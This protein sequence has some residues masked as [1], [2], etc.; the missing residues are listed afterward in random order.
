MSERSFGANAVLTAVGWVIPAIAALVAVPI[1]VRG[2]GAD[3]FGLLAL[4][5]ALS[6]YLS[7]LDLGLGTAIVRYLAY[8]CARNEGRTMLQILRVA[9]LWFSVIG[10]LGG[11]IM[12]TQAPALAGI[13][14]VSGDLEPVAVTVVRLAG[15][16]FFL[17]MLMSAGTAI[18]QAFLR[19][20]LAAAVSGIIGTASAVGPAVLVATGHGIVAVVVFSIITNLVALILYA[21]IAVVLFRGVSLRSGPTWKEIRRV[22]L[23]FT[24]MTAL[25]RV[26]S[27]IA[28]QTNRLLVGVAGGA[29]AMAYYQVPNLL[30]SKVNELLSRV[31]QVI[32]PTGT[33]RI[34][35]QNDEG[36]R[37]LYLRTSRLFFVLNA[38][39]SVAV[40]A[41]AKPLLSTWVSP[42]F[43][44]KGALA[45]VI[46]TL[47]QG[48]NA[49]SMSASYVNL[50]YERPGVNLVFSAL[51]SVLNL[52]TVV[53]LVMAY[54]ISGAASAG[55]VGSAMVPAFLVYSDRRVIHVSSLVVL[56]ACYLPSILGSSVVGLL[57]YRFLA[58]QAESLVVVVGLV[59]FTALAATCVSG[60]LGAVKRDDVQLGRAIL[61]RAL[62]R[63][64]AKRVSGGDA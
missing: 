34:A 62:G 13:I 59:L 61:R 38:S 35:D 8:H 41:F 40:C 10:F 55:L 5:T 37:S 6:G 52:A 44:E 51:N 22:V 12:V 2:L 46:F 25:T 23:R 48:V 47:A 57:A 11:L 4:V 29:A 24:G 45:L 19:Y 50:A 31:G 58:P 32:L 36:T 15:V 49:A 1:T 33:Q 20:D 7:L 60:L 30:S 28:A 18:P 64:R 54:G 56:R 17:G 21:V 43:A 16:S 27:A 9:A 63:D 26:H 53:P 14:G 39:I 3:T 42:Q